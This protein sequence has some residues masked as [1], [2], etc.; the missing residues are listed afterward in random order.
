MIAVHSI[1]A[2]SQRPQPS[3]SQEGSEVPEQG[4]SGSTVQAKDARTLWQSRLWGSRSWLGKCVS[5]LTTSIAVVVVLVE[6]HG[7]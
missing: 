2:R 4:Q 6:Y 5:I 3:G 1:G 7:C